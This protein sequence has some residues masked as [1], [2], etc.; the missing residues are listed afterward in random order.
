[1]I[2][3]PGL[4]VMIV[5]RRLFE[6]DHHRFFT[7]VVDAY[8]QGIVKVMGN[9]WI[10]DVFT[11]EPKRKEGKRTKIFSIASGT[12]MLYE[13]PETAQMDSLA[14]EFDKDRRLILCDG[15]H[16][17]LDLT[18]SGHHEPVKKRSQL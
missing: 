17:R 5:H 9:S 7:G 3:E 12:V 10:Y 4:K 18:E 13:L 2:L 15:R 16:L 11:G 14:F 1:M 6:T 8:E